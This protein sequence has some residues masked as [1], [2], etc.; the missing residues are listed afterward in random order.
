MAIMIAEELKDL[1]KR[2]LEA[3]G[4]EMPNEIHLEHPD[5]L[6]RGDYATNMAMVLAKRV[7]KSPHELAEI[8]IAK[9]EESKPETVE[10]VEIA[11]PGFI[12]FHLSLKFLTNEV[13]RVLKMGDDYGRNQSRQGQKIIIEF[14][15]PNP[16]KE[17][18]IGHLMSNAI[19]ES[20]S[21]LIAA[22]GAEL[23]RACY[24]G[25]VGMHVA[26]TLLSLMELP[27]DALPV[28][29]PL[30]EKA[31][32]LGDAYAKGSNLYES[33]E[34]EKQKA[35]DLNK[36]IYDRTDPKVNKL[37]DWGREVSLEYFETIYGKL[38]T[39]FDHY[40]FESEAGPYGKGVVE[41]WLEKGV[42]E[43]S[44]GAVVYKGDE[45]EGL[46]TRVFINSQDL[47]TYEA[48]ELGLAKIK[49]DKY[50][51]EHSL[52]ITGNEIN[53]YF[54]V[55]LAVMG[56]VFPNLAAKTTHLGH[57]MLRLPS[58]KMS[59]R[60]GDVITA[61]SL[62]TE[63][64]SKI[65]PKIVD[66]GLTEEEKGIIAEQVAVGAIKYSIL[67]QAV[68]GDIIFDLEN[69]VSFEGDSGP[70]IQ[71]TYARARSVLSKAKG[72]DPNLD[73]EYPSNAGP[74]G[75]SM[76]KSSEC[77]VER[78]LY[79]FHEIVA[80][81]ATDYAPHQLCTY[82][83]QLAS[84]FNTYYGETKIIDEDSDSSYR[85]ALTA[86]TAQVLKSGLHLLGIAAPEK[87]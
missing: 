49:Y 25:D 41:E 45:E 53:D 68:G 71:Y 33:G 11:G 22:T 52:V 8:I 20:I 39:K 24:Q 79:R 83:H 26:K 64:R 82:L 74:L 57:G 61:E 34:G 37:Y 59:S 6:V 85:L 69:S 56:E 12:N 4:L 9:L 42:F 14:T 47:P 72:L 13:E 38:G 18:H 5:E 55:L 1:I 23:K 75:Y 76:S 67:H 48:K 65:A 2:A 28:Q 40:F 54:R 32:F 21:R 87:M 27:D 29:A 84:A 3:L 78:L 17:F 16:F 77:H 66:R 86:A 80:Q 31:A 62:L 46:H 36:K 7:G 51:Y 44:D 10:K 15:D 81:A 63:V 19:G 50:P 73:I 70:Y 43:K 35:G 30:Q 58:G 60:T